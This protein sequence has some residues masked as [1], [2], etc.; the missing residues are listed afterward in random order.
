MSD[1]V[2]RIEYSGRRT[3]RLILHLGGKRNPGN[4]NKFSPTDSVDQPYS[5]ESHSR[6]KRGRSEG[7]RQGVAYL[8]AK[9]VGYRMASDMTRHLDEDERG[10]HTVDTLGGS[11]E[12]TVISEA[13]LYSAVLRSEIT[14]SFSTSSIYRLA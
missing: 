12:M 3:R 11:Q 4:V 9:A 7:K 8:V 13:C 10:I 5:K 6:S 1:V 2:G 14:G